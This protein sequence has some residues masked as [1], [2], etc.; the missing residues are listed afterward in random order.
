MSVRK[1]NYILL[2]KLNWPSRQASKKIFK[3]RWVFDIYIYIMVQIIN[4][5]IS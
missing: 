2:L 5:N 3:V 1:T 4:L